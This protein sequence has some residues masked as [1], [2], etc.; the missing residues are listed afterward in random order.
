MGGYLTAQYAS[1]HPERVKAYFMILPAATEP[2]LPDNYKPA[3]Y[4]SF[5]DPEQYQ[6]PA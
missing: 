5:L 4:P 3:E 1:A 6:D 2:Y